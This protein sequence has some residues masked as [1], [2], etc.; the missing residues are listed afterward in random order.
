MRFTGLR[1]SLQFT[2]STRTDYVTYVHDDVVTKITR[3]IAI[4]EKREVRLVCVNNS[5][6]TFSVDMFILN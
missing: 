4:R 5:T 6:K 1:N 3:H 2:S